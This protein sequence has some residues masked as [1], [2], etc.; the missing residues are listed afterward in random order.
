MD[1]HKSPCESSEALGKGMRLYQ[2]S[3]FMPHVL[4]FTPLKEKKSIPVVKYV[5]VE[6]QLLFPSVGEE[7]SG[8]ED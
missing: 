5:L 4:D 1:L 3:A 7:I 2:Q 8:R 6:S